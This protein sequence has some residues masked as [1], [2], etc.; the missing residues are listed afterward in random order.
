MKHLINLV[1]I[2]NVFLITLIFMVIS[3]IVVS[4]ALLLNRIEE[5][6]D[7]INSTSNPNHKFKDKWIDTIWGN[8]NDGIDGDIYYL[9]YHVNNKRN[10]WTRF[11]WTVLRNPVHNLSLKLGFN[12]KLEYVRILRLPFRNAKFSRLNVVLNKDQMKT[13]SCIYKNELDSKK[14]KQGFEYIEVNKKYP[15]YRIR[16]KYPFLN[17]GLKVNLG[18]KNWNIDQGC[19]VDYHYTF[20]FTINPFKKFE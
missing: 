12:G 8:D 18:W 20:T 17:R 4:I 2:I 19:D 9:Q 14:E 3:P 1:K 11:N 13:N 15:M 7:C 16:W 10:F 6:N 5:K